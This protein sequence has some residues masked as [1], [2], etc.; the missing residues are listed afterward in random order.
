MTNASALARKLLLVLITAVLPATAAV[1]AALDK[2]DE[3]TYAVIRRDQRTGPV[4]RLFQRE[5]RWQIDQQDANGAWTSATCEKE[6]VLA[7]SSSADIERFFGKTP[8]APFTACLHNTAFAFCRIEKPGDAG[9]REYLFVALT[10]KA[11]IVL[12][13]ARQTAQAS[14]NQ[15]SVDGFSGLVL[16]TTDADWEAKWNTPPETHPEFHTVSTIRRGVTVFVLTFFTNPKLDGDGSAEIGCSIEIVRPDGAVSSKQEEVP[17]F[18][19]RLA[20]PQNTYLTGA[21]IKFVGDPEDPA[22][23]WQ[24][25]VTIKDRVRNVALP[26]IAELT[27]QDQ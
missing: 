8:Q 16:V 18:K 21:V 23:L 14:S 10:E 6:C 5:G 7:A 15:K 1:A 3:G 22:G 17:C 24:F 19:A 9:A 26:L 25:K 11:P 20:I 2:N 27:L 4:M 13:L 12:K